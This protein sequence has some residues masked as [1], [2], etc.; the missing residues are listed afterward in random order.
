MVR[1]VR[2][3]LRVTAYALLGALLAMVAPDAAADGRI[4]DNLFLLEEA[5]NQEPGVIQHISVFQMS[6]RTRG[7]SY[8]YTDEW[9]VPA[10]LHQ[11]SVTL[12]VSGLPQGGPVSFGDVLLNYRLQ[13]LGR[14]GKGTVA[15]APRLSMVLPTGSVA[16]GTGR[17]AIGVQVA[18][19]VSIEMGRF[20]VTHL[21]AGLTVTPSAHAPGGRTETA[22]DA[23]GGLA[24]VW[25]PVS[26]MNPL[27][28][29]VY[30]N[31]E[32]LM[33]RG[34]R[35]VASV[36]VNPGLRL[37]ID[38]PGTGLQI[39]PG[40]GAPIRLWPGGDREVG[41]VGYLSFEHPTFAAGDTGE[42]P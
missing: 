2:F 27:V 22:L 34:S 10:D 7:W 5:Y 35:R 38:V 29:V 41:V 39:V 14:G 16:K 15:M 42:R 8:S 25:Q 23:T 6:P 13:A 11:L 18:L 36:V 32:E 33:A 19:P 1:D 31:E 28:E 20:F 30:R 26:W 9:P 17:G 37:A 4:R 21:N 3:L 24:M 12:D 40:V